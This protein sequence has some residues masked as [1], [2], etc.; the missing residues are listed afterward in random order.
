MASPVASQ[1]FHRSEQKFGLLGPQYYLIHRIFTIKKAPLEKGAEVHMRKNIF[2]R[3]CLRDSAHPGSW[4]SGGAEEE[5]AGCFF[6][7]DS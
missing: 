2:N 4:S 5:P 1:S 7:N 3:H 6:Q